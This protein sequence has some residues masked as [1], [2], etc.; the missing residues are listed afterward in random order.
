M[1]RSTI[2]YLLLPTLVL[3]TV[4]VWVFGQN[5]EYMPLVGIPGIDPGAQNIE[6]YLN[7]LYLLAIGV[8][9]LIAVIKI[10]L[11]G[12]KLMFSEIV[13][14]REDAKKDMTGALLGLLIILAGVTILN[15]INPQ[16]TNF[17]IFDAGDRIQVQGSREN[18]AWSPQ[19]VNNAEE[20]EATIETCGEAGFTRSPLPGGG[21]R[22][23]ITCN[24][25]DSTGTTRDNDSN[26]DTSEDTNTQEA[27]GGDTNS[28]T[29]GGREVPE[30][31]NWV[32]D[33]D[34]VD[35]HFNSE[36]LEEICTTQGGVADIAQS[37]TGNGAVQCT[38]E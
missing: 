2:Y 18:G 12:V 38:R 16:L 31:G 25:P 4:P 37:S 10:I 32:M 23:V 6:A 8:A 27:S 29:Y 11:A 30:E 9:A 24:E 15:E 14:S 17:T 34:I 36:P 5:K 21:G 7:G 33:V 35:G 3:L 13:T 22:E 26:T 20:A 1:Q 28:F 19:V